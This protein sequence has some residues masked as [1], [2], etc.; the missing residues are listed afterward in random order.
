MSIS[1]ASRAFRQALMLDP[2]VYCGARSEALDHIAPKSLGGSDLLHNRAPVCRRCNSRK[3]TLSVLQFLWRLQ[4]ERDGRTTEQ[5]V[6]HKFVKG[7][8]VPV[9]VRTVY[10]Y[11]RAQRAHPVRSVPAS[12]GEHPENGQDL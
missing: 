12:V 1:T 11:E 4:C 2:C 6:A 9:S 5:V 3:T 7:K 8:R 10:P